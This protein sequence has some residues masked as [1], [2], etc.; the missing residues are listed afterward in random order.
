[1]TQNQV[2]TGITI[3]TAVLYSVLLIE[4][5]MQKKNKGNNSNEEKKDNK[6]H[7]GT[8]WTLFD[9]IKHNFGKDKIFTI[10]WL[11]ITGF[12]LFVANWLTQDFYDS[13]VQ[14][15]QAKVFHY[16]CLFTTMMFGPC[17]FLMY[18]VARNTTLLQP[19]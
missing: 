18:N 11:G 3:G 5:Y 12:D 7:S 17:G 1:M 15:P 4:S 2:V 19:K 8:K 16:C 9:K 13:Y 6:K 14:T 10:I